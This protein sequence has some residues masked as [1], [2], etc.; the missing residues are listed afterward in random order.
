[1]SFL[2]ESRRKNPDL[3]TLIATLETIKQTD[4]G[5]HPKIKPS[6]RHNNA[7][8]GAGNRV[9]ASIK[10]VPEITPIFKKLVTA[11]SPT[12]KK[13]MSFMR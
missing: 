2:R 8:T 1:M 9:K 11:C 12:S 3:I 6:T 7:T 4:P 5:N 10:N 13:E